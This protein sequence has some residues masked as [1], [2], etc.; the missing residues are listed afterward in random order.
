[1]SRGGGG[2]DMSI[3][4]VIV[5]TELWPYLRDMSFGLIVRL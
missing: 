1:M 4:H 3:I 2:S 5:R